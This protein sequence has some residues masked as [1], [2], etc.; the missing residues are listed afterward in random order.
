MY[1]AAHPRVKNNEVPPADYRV[2]KDHHAPQ[3][4]Y[5]YPHP[6]LV[7]CINRRMVVGATTVNHLV[8]SGTNA[9]TQKR[10]PGS[11][12][13]RG[14]LFSEHRNSCQVIADQTANQK[15]RP[16]MLK[17]HLILV[18]ADFKGR[19]PPFPSD[20]LPGN[21]ADDHQRNLRRAGVR[22]AR[23]EIWAGTLPG[24]VTS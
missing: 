17:L 16:Y 4:E 22:I 5:C 23:D 12:H 15:R 18:C 19:N 3:N 13:C 21:S 9:K 8:L 14:F 2:G 6:N 1:Q 7:S 10:N 20:E 24:Y 11:S